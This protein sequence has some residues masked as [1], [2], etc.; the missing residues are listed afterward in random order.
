MNPLALAV[1]VVWWLLLVGFALVLA[2]AAA[3]PTPRPPRRD[4]V[5]VALDEVTFEWPRDDTR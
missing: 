5:L 3:R 1:I 2:K 4:R